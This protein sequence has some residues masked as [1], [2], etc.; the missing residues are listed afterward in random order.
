M[1]NSL[2]NKQWLMLRW[3][4][5]DY[6]PGISFSDEQLKFFENALKQIS[7]DTDTNYVTVFA[8]RPGIGKS[9]F[10]RTLIL[11]LCMAF[12]TGA[13]VITDLID[14]LKGYTF[15]DSNIY[16]LF[17][18][19]DDGEGLTIRE[20]LERRIG[21]I[22]SNPDESVQEQL[23]RNNNKQII[24]LT[25]QRYF[26][27]NQHSR[28]ILFSYTHDGKKYPRNLVFM[29]EKPY[30]VQQK[31]IDF[32]SMT[33][34]YGALLKG[35]TDQTEDKAW[36]LD[37]YQQTKD[38]LI[39][40]MLKT[41]QSI[42]NDSVRMFLRPEKKTI[43]DDDKRFF[44]I[45]EKNQTNITR[46]YAKAFEELRL[47][48]RI[49]V[50]GAIFINS[51]VKSAEKTYSSAFFLPQDNR[52]AFYLGGDRKFFVFDGTADIDPDY[53]LDY[54]KVFPYK[55]YDIPLNLKITSVNVPTSRRTLGK[56]SESS[57]EITSAIRQFI[58]EKH[59]KT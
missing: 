31:T 19:I 7:E 30:F 26:Q 2:T 6:L 22:Y 59:G 12:N 44:G 13:I 5:E 34:I 51:K 49:L 9:T 52:D 32:S 39:D 46:V 50:E 40:L 45:I 42:S 47:I 15:S 57:E 58:K 20:Q 29:D 10:V 23:V 3:Y 56:K 41:E 37:Q 35:L 24:L 27:M 54:V 25:T 36:I 48:Q 11:T 4:F 38:Y 18:I 16:Y 8:G 21:I 17:D 28:E 33:S 1:Y 14:R 43:S 53:R 55:A